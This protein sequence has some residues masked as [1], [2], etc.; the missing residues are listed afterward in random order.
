MDIYSFISV[1]GCVG[2]GPSAMFCPGVYT[3]VKT[4]PI[5]TYTIVFIKYIFKVKFILTMES[6]QP[7]RYIYR[8]LG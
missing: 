1:G 8:Y 5:S 7:F 4:T 3:A 2:M 6:W